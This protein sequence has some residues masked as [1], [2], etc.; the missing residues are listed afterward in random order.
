MARLITGS[1]FHP[2]RGGRR[3]GKT[4]WFDL[5]VVAQDIT[6]TGGQI[7]LTMVASELAARPFTVLRTHLEILITS[8]QLAADELQA[9]AVGLCVVS[10]QAAAVGVT[11]VPTPATD[12]A[13]DLWFAHQWCFNRFAFASGVGFDASEGKVYTIDSKAMRK[14][15]NDQQILVITELG[16]VS[17]GF[18]LIVAGRLLIKEH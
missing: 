16:S 15:N 10:D 13:S 12:A 8:D 1:R 14:V 3:P 7:L 17:N 9:G 5:P 4:T 6:T 11:A 2:V 18:S